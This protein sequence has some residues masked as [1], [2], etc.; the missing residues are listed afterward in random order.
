[1]QLESRTFMNLKNFALCAVAAAIMGCNSDTSNNTNTLGSV[2]LSGTALTGESLSASVNDSDGI[3]TDITYYWYAD[4]EMI[5]G[6]N[7]SSFT[8]TDQQVGLPVTVQALY[9]DDGGINE[10]HLSEPTDNVSAVAFDSTVTLTGDALIGST[11]T[12][13]VADE[14]G[15]DSDT[16]IYTWFA[17][18][19]EIE[20]EVLLTLE[21]TEAQLDAAITVMATFV[22][23]R[24]FEESATS[25]A[26]TP[27]KR[28]NFEGDVIVQGTP[29]FG[30]TLTA[31]PSDPDGLP[32]EITYQ[33]F[34]DDE[35]IAGE[36]QSTYVVD[37]SLLGM[38]I[39]VQVTYIDDYDFPEDNLSEPVGPVTE[40][41][42]DEPGSVEIS[43]VVPYLADAP[44]TAEVFDNNGVDEA[45]ISY[46]WL[47]D[48]VE[49]VGE[50]SKTFTPSD[51]AGAIISV[52]ATYNDNDNFPEATVEGAL[53]TL[54]YSQI[55]SDANELVG[56]VN[57]GL[58][59]GTVV[60]LKSNNYDDMEPILL[61]SAVTLRAV[62]GETP[63]ILGETCFHVA[64]GVVGAEI[65]GLSFINIDTKID[66][67]CDLEEAAV[68]YS[69]GDDFVFS[70]NTMDGEDET[71][72]N[73]AYHWMVL[74]GNNALIERNTFTNRDN[75]LEGSVIKMASSS[76]DHTLQYNLF[77][78][79]ID[80]GDEIVSYDSSLMLINV[81]N[82][83]GNAAATDA[84]LTVQYNRVD[85]FITGRRLMRVQTSGATI[86][87]NTV[88]NPNGAI[89]LED[90]GYNTVTDNIMIRT[91]EIMDSD[92]RPGGVLI[93]PL[94]H[95]V[96]NN[97][98]AGIRAD[99]KETGGIV[100][101]A[102]PLSQGDGGVPRDGN[103]T[104]LDNPGDFTLNVNKNTVLNSIQPIVFSTEVG[105]KVSA[106]DCDDLNEEF[107]ETL[108]GLT[109]N[110][111]VINFDAN[112]IANG[113]NDNAEAQGLFLPFDASSSDH[114]FEY[115]CDLINHDESVFSNNFGFSD[116][117]SSG[118]VED[119]SWVDIRGV[120]GNGKFDSDGA[121]DQN[122]AENDKEEPDFV[123]APNTL[124]ET[125]PEG[126]QG[127]AGAKG[128]HY[129]QESEVGVGDTWVA[130]GD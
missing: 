120:N 129:I 65:S 121:I 17:D 72:N 125:N 10:S 74:Q 40:F 110:F 30:D 66:S 90:G 49:V 45:N 115:D 88:I 11:L 42:I 51:Y 3:S 34:V 24:G 53:T 28:V 118:D 14:N 25:S 9:T 15:F 124:T 123:T 43:G 29:A 50:N 1:M 59:D 44:L 5:S 68:I 26:T 27:V 48:G 63:K 55:V 62:E 37:P 101:T 39:T 33:W 105:S 104:I 32:D 122:P 84:N 99:G 16:V 58:A 111:F 86:K 128:L 21:L 83:T 114:S 22:D 70:E 57:T 67:F 97:Y 31:V 60:G 81:G 100:F 127:G 56:A 91:S 20:D 46:T 2:S 61:T 112:L 35:A 80:E 41:A 52:R 98:I 102:N 82:T 95:T 108:Y 71:L 117:Y 73:E 4:G 13:N 85:N 12:A 64:S 89:S 19:V 126:A 103:Q 36:T 96:S 92:D 69:E 47:A 109:K 93:T 77:T 119:E 75:A 94:G 107:H 87:G 130:Q 7:S 8:L 106:D 6:A 18:G 23:D 76:V 54:V 38:S 79:E 116:S 113:L 78:N